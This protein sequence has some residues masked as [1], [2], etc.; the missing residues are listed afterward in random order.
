MEDPFKVV[1]ECARPRVL[2]AVVSRPAR[3]RL[4]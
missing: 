4:G 2:T 1:K 3:S